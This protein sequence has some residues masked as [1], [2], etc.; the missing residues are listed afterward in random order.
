[1]AML[2]HNTAHS[3]PMKYTLAKPPLAYPRPFASE[4]SALCG[5]CVALGVHFKTQGGGIAPHHRTCA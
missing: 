5:V 3:K 1:M 4:P 2:H